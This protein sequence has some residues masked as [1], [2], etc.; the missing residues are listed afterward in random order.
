ML[1][2]KEGA[3]VEIVNAIKR[4][5]QGEGIL[6]LQEIAEAVHEGLA[7]GSVWSPDVKVLAGHLLN[8]TEDGIRKSIAMQND[9]MALAKKS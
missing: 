9:A 3:K 5:R 8:M 6:T 2:G 7:M 4:T 1:E